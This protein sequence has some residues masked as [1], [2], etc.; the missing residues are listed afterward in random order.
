M[1]SLTAASR[2]IMRD[3]KAAT[4]PRKNEGAT[5]FEKICVSLSMFG[6]N[7]M[8]NC[9]DAW[10]K[11]GTLTRPGPQPDSY[12]AAIGDLFR[13]LRRRGRATSMARKTRHHRSLAQVASR[14]RDFTYEELS[15][16]HVQDNHRPQK[17]A[18]QTTCETQAGQIQRG[19][20]A[21]AQHA[22]ERR[23][24]PA[25]DPQGN[26]SDASHARYGHCDA[27]KLLAQQQLPD[28]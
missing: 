22:D 8:L 27:G 6:I 9:S 4:A 28:E 19:Q 10:D 11:A 26:Q 17:D 24:W 7:S 1:R 20:H 12:T 14:S 21:V 5:A 23:T 25:G 3:T 2:D 16:D 15:Q 18:G 13:L